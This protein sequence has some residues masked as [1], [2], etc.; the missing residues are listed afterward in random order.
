MTLPKLNLRDLFWLVLVVAMGLGWWMEHQ[1]AKAA[2]KFVVESLSARLSVS[3][4]NEIKVAP[5]DTS[6]DS[7]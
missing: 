3:G 1:R 4:I 5:S 2:Y 6:G 7:K